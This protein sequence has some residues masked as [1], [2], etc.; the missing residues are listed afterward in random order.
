MNTKLF[1]FVSIT[2]C[3][4]R[5]GWQSC[6]PLLLQDSFPQLSV[7]IC[8]NQT[9]PSH[10]LTYNIY[11]VNHKGFMYHTIQLILSLLFFSLKS[12]ISWLTI[13]SL[14]AQKSKQMQLFGHMHFLSSY[15]N[16]LIRFELMLLAS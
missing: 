6:T 12:G 1:Y 3:P 5:I 4:L 16:M 10:S 9:R 8:R 7:P 14:L 2:G 15:T 13:L 11:Q